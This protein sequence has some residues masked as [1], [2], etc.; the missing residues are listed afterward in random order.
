MV[1]ERDAEFILNR[2]KPLIESTIDDVDVIIL[3]STLH[4]EFQKNITP[5]E[6]V[7]LISFVKNG[8]SL[9]IFVDEESHRVILDEYNINSVLRPFG[10][11]FGQDLDLPGNCG[12]VSL[13]GEIFKGRYEVPYSGSR[14]LKG[15]I[16]ASV[17]ME[18]GY[19]HSAYVTLHNGGKL[20]ACAEIMVSLLMGGE[21]DRVRKGPITFNQTGWFGKDSR[22]FIGDLLDWAMSIN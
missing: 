18:E 14:T 19:L 2:E 9:I 5:E 13:E 15:G 10:M 8:G 20:Y 17:C 22:K 7:A 6:A 1:E 4:H 16:P 21:E 12:A 11:E 3:L